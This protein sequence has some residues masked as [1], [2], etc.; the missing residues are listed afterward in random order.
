MSVLENDFTCRLP[1]ALLALCAHMQPNQQTS[2]SKP[3][4]S[5]FVQETIAYTASDHKMRVE[6]HAKSLAVILFCVTK[7]LLLRLIVVEQFFCVRRM[8]MCVC[9]LSVCMLI[10]LA[11]AREWRCI[12][13]EVIA[14]NHCEMIGVRQS[15]NFQWHAE[16][17]EVNMCQK[18]K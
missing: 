10:V 11:C 9:K 14:C 15:V 8:C 12:V 1:P 6:R 17:R 3:C 2:P 13:K 5:Y 18:K 7:K 16:A 4:L